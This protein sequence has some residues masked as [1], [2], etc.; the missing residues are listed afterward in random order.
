MR[1]E[2]ITL[3]IP[4]YP[5]HY[6]YIYSLLSKCRENDIDID[7]HLIFSNEYEYTLFE[8]KD[9]V[10]KIICKNLNFNSMTTHK[11]FEGLKY[12]IGSTY[13]YII[14]CDSEIDII[15]EHFNSENLNHKIKDIFENKKIY[16]GTVTYELAQRILSISASLFP[17]EYET[18]KEITH[19]FTDYFWWSDLPVY[20]T[21]DLVPFFDK[22]NYSAIE[23]CHFDYI[24][25]QYYLILSHGFELVNTT[26]ITS[27]LWSLECFSTTDSSILNGL[28]DIGFGFSWIPKNMYLQNRPFIEEQKG[29]VIYHLDRF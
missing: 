7:I 18:L 19:H 21:S 1:I 24:I 16:S 17:S 9:Q 8:K 23:S 13:E 10:K 25:Y 6:S 22:I 14:C 20:R 2:N 11:K 28:L 27:H 5:P 4:T 3:L 12:L 26:I 29:C 15:P